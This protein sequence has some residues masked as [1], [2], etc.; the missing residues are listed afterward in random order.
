M[1]SRTPLRTGSSLHLIHTQATNGT[2]LIHHILKPIEF[3][4]EC[5]DSI[6]NNS[7][8]VRVAGVY[9]Q[10]TIIPTVYATVSSTSRIRFARKNFSRDVLPTSG[11]AM[12]WTSTAPC[13]GNTAVLI[14][15]T[16]S[17]P[18]GRSLSSLRREL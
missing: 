16:L 6:Y 14:C 4:L 18:R 9:T 17:Y 13:S 15:T 8:F 10:R 7:I 5:I 12:R 11:Y 1:A 3:S 2:L